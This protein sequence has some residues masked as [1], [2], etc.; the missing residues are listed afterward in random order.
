MRTDPR[1]ACANEKELLFWAVIHDLV[2]HPMMAL[3]GYSKS[4]LTF[5]D[6]TSR[7]AWPRDTRNYVPHIETYQSERFGVLMIEAKAPGF[8]RIHH[9]IIDHTFGTQASDVSDAIEKAEDW[10]SSLAEIAPETADVHQH[11][12]GMPLQ[13]SDERFYRK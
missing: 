11:W 4:S 12:T 8:F 6:W 3:T 13:P 7:H 1:V 5:H 2:A 9:G 10:F